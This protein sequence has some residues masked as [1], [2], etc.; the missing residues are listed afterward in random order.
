MCVHYTVTAH[1]YS[2]LLP[3]A[4]PPTPPFPTQCAYRASKEK[5]GDNLIY[6]LFLH[7]KIK[8]NKQRECQACVCPLIMKSKV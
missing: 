4:R 6:F 3:L 2:R 8:L 7:R 1:Y 5:P